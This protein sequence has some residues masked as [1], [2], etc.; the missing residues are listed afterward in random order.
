VVIKVLAKIEALKSKLSD[1]N[2]E[3]LRLFWP[4]LVEH[5][6]AITIGIVSAIMVSGVGDFAVSGVTMVDTFNF[7]IIAIFTALAVGATVVVA[8]K[9]G[10]HK[11]SEAGETA[12][13]SI[14][15]CVSIASILGMAVVLFGRNILNVIYAGAAENVH[16]A[17]RTYFLFSGISYPFVGL[18]AA[19]TGVMRAGGNTR[20][21]MISS[22]IANVVNITLAFILIQAG[23]GVLGVSI[24]MLSARTVAGT[25]A[26]IVVNKGVYGFAL[27]GGKPRLSRKI[28]KPVLNV[29]VPS[30]VDAI[31]F[32]GARVV[33]TVFMAGMGTAALHAHAI[34][35][36]LS[37]FM[38]LPGNAMA[39]VSVTLVGQA[40]GAKLYG[41]VKML[42]GRVCLFCSGSHVIM[43]LIFIFLISPLIRLYNPTPYAEELSLRLIMTM[44]ILSPIVWSFSFAMPQMLRACGDAKSTMYVS[45]ASLLL[46]RILGAWFFGI[47][48]EWGVFG[49]WMG[50]FIDW[51][52]RGIGFS[53][54]AFSNAWNGGR[55]PVDETKN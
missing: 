50:M 10:A 12:F 14:V 26:F 13:Q 49:V 8:Q 31:I 55:K 51:F 23:L 38:F 44:A 24:A 32:N 47:Y 11:I 16:Q 46:L 36:S 25:F 45:V 5:T 22:A 21:P 2:R 48:L 39:I 19:C 28:L 3:M 40:Y 43:S 17:M 18:F 52:G 9:I 29:G 7:M 4:V 6:L 15:L 33:M 20:T 34:A 27:P 37:G 41:R 42:M 1:T 35:N 53:V 54:R 30:G